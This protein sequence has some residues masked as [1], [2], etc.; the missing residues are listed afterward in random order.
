MASP[1]SFARLLLLTSALIAPSGM[2]AAQ[3]TPDQAETM[4]TETATPDPQEMD[5]SGAA[6]ATA[7]AEDES[8]ETETEVSIPGTIVVVGRRNA[9]VQKAAPAVVSVL[10]SADIQR[11]GEGDIAGALSRVTGLSVVGNGFV[12]VRGLGDRYSLALLNGSPLP[13][14]EPLKR[15]VP[16]DLFPTSVV[17]SSLVQKSYSANFPGEFG[18]GVINLTTKS[19]PN[20]DFLSI[21]GGIGG[22]S[23]TSRQLG[24]TYYGS[25]TDWTG[26]DN[27]NRDY[28]AVLDAF[29]ASG[30]RIGNVDSQ[31]I[32]K[33]LVSSRSVLVQRNNDIPFNFSAEISAGKTIEI[34]S[35]ELGIIA[36]AGFSNKWRT[37]QTLQQTAQDAALTAV[38]T[39]FTKVQTDNRVVVN[40]LLGFGLEF[41]RNKLRWTNVYVR[42]TLKQASLSTGVKNN[43]IVG[44]DYMDQSTAWYERQLI[45]TQLVGE[46]DLD[47]LSV[48]IRAA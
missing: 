8:A 30:E 42:D 34:G 41:G 26:F 37:R 7:P 17:A 36:S 27:G 13:S 39:D 24:Y 10:S 33:A 23:E 44:A 4:A 32:G 43:S 5:A 48:D 46:F 16:L 6:P 15:V 20:E 40:G 14:P 45:D 19:T 2:A 11:T 25:S 22:N 1:L 29:L 18:G 21:S 3:E 31:A 28:P 35:S 9:N 47:G 12:Y 38:D